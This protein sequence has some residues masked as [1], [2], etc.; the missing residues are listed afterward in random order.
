M[1]FLYIRQLDAEDFQVLGWKEPHDGNS[2]MTKSH[3][4]TGNLAL[5]PYVS[6]K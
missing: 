5:D 3:L 6:D 4:L 2:H 1:W